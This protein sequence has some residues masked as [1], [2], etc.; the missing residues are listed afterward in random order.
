MMPVTV[1]LAA[2]TVAAAVFFI[3]VRRDIFEPG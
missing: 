1:T 3:A 2:V